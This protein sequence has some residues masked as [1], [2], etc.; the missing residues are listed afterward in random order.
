MKKRIIRIVCICIV[1]WGMLLGE[2]CI[3]KSAF[4]VNKSNL[5]EQNT[6]ET[7]EVWTNFNNDGLKKIVTEKYNKD[8]KERMKV[9]FKVIPDKYSETINVAMMSGE[10]P[11][12]FVTLSEQQCKELVDKN[13]VEDLSRYM[14]AQYKS[15]FIDSAFRNNINVFDGKVYGIP[16]NVYSHKLLYNADLFRKAGI[17][18]D[19]PPRTL[20]EL[21]EYAKKIT[22]AGEGRMFGI[23]LPMLQPEKIGIN[24]IDPIV[25]RSFGIVK[26]YDVEKGTYDFLAYKPVLE[27][28]RK[29]YQ[30]K[31]MYP[32]SPTLDDDQQAEQFAKGNIGMAFFSSDWTYKFGKTEEYQ[33][34]FDIKSCDIPFYGEKKKYKEMLD[35]SSIWVMSSYSKNKDEA[36]KLMKYIASEESHS[37]QALVGNV[38][39]F[40]KNVDGHSINPAENPVTKL[41]VIDSEYALIPALPYGL[42]TEG[43]NPDTVFAQAILTDKNIE[44]ELQDLNE[45]YNAM[46]KKSIEEDKNKK[47]E[48]LYQVNPMRLAYDQ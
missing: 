20:T 18:P 8:N 32:T 31:T 39:S 23:S 33:Y 24:V 13:Q 45:R 36:F 14:N 42:V 47:N 38:Y 11:D 37:T 10:T 43:N 25:C 7:L 26:G 48:Y 3:N 4:S 19:K 5:H 46:W 21:M 15:D 12:V 1:F 44:K 29:A 41:F 27:I 34:N 28:W 30:A 40:H 6:G 16:A 9:E 17:D 2:G 22:E 35:G